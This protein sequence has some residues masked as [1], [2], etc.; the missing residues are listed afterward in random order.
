MYR[1]SGYLPPLPSPQDDKAR[2]QPPR[3]P[4]AKKPYPDKVPYNILRINNV[5]TRVRFQHILS[6]FAPCSRQIIGIYR[7]ADYTTRRMGNTIY[8]VLT[9]DADAMMLEQTKIDLIEDGR[10]EEMIYLDDLMYCTASL[11]ERPANM[12]FEQVPIGVHVSGLSRFKDQEGYTEY[13]MSLVHHF[14]NDAI[15]TSIRLGYDQLRKCTRKDAFLTFLN[16]VDASIIAGEKKPKE[17]LI[18]GQKVNAEFSSNIPMLVRQVDYERLN[19]GKIPWSPVLRDMNRLMTTVKIH[20]IPPPP[21]VRLT[22]QELRA[23]PTVEILPENDLRRIQSAPANTQPSTSG[24]ARRPSPIRAPTTSSAS[25]VT[26]PAYSTNPQVKPTPKAAKE[27]DPPKEQRKVRVQTPGELEICRT[28][29]APNNLPARN[30]RRDDLE[31][32]STEAVCNLKEGVHKPPPEAFQAPKKQRQFEADRSIVV[33]DTPP[34][35]HREP[36]SPEYSS[37]SISP[38]EARLILGEDIEFSDEEDAVPK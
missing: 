33:V 6:K 9:S 20:F 28:F 12:R 13:L 11:A 16:Q 27:T 3:R 10:R 8:L 21:S 1:R 34:I 25:L 18:L 38:N 5:P 19:L 31:R 23:C 37:G 30:K 2:K 29:S 24:L 36:P 26:K 14:E 4:R 17:H 35:V 22:I 7:S 32:L 15:L